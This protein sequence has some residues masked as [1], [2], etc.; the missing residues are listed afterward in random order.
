M[1]GQ[2]GLAHPVVRVS[3]REA[4]AFCEW[5]TATWLAKGRLQGDWR[6]GLPSEAE[7]EKGARGGARIPRVPLC[8]T[9]KLPPTPE[10]SLV[11]HA[12]PGC[13][14][15]FPWG[16]EA[17]DADRANYRDAGIHSTTGVGSFPL[18]ASPY[19]CED[20][21]GNVWEWTRSIYK[22][23]PYDLADREREDLAAGP[24]ASR[25]VRGGPFWD[26]SMYMRCA[27]RRGCFAHGRRGGDCGFRVVLSPFR[28]SGA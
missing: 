26:V 5:L 21:A 10:P 28:D 1:A 18:G 14:C 2:P 8:H 20:M 24:G 22:P 15:R 19:G 4:V 17:P 27:S 23:Y 6:V 12:A 11:H 25:V 7:W 9:L 3:W 16:D 13:Y